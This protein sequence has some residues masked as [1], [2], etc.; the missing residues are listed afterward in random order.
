MERM[1]NAELDSHSYDSSDQ[2][3]QDSVN[4]GLPLED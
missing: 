2:A 3:E 1:T 4:M